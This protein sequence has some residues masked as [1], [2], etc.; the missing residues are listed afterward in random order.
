VTPPQPRCQVWFVASFLLGRPSSRP[1]S[2]DKS[3][4]SRRHCWQH[5]A[6]YSLGLCSPSR[7]SRTCRSGLASATASAPGVAAARSTATST[8]CSTA[9]SRFSSSPE[10]SLSSP[11]DYGPESRN[12]FSAPGSRPYPRLNQG[13][14]AEIDPRFLPALASL[15]RVNRAWLS[16]RI[17]S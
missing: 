16:A 7:S 12:A 14:G 15:R 1:C 17:A 8:A 9:L 4:A 3:V 5:L 10:G 13:W 2:T 11:L 6:R